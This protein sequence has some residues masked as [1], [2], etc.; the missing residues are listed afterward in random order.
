M[1][2]PADLAYVQ[3]QVLATTHRFREELVSPERLDAVKKHLRYS[4]SLGMDNNESI[5]ATV[6]QYIAL[7]RTPETINRIYALYAQLTP[8]DIRQAARQCFQENS[9]TIVTLTGAAAGQGGAR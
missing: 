7:R 5:A 4:F 2:K 8:E 3:E 6:S 9:R 1:K